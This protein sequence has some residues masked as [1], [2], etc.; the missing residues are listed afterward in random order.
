VDTSTRP[1]EAVTGFAEYEFQAVP[2]AVHASKA[3]LSMG[4]DSRLNVDPSQEGYR[5]QQAQ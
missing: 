1:V 3:A 2:S 4:D 5:Y